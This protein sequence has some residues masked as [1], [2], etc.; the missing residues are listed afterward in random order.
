MYQVSFQVYSFA[1]G[2]I[3]QYHRWHGL[4]NTNFLSGLR[5]QTSHMSAGF[6]L[7]ILP[8]WFSDDHLLTGPHMSLSPCVYNRRISVSV[9]M[10]PSY[11]NTSNTGLGPTRQVILTSLFKGPMSTYSHI[12]GVWASIY[13]FWGD[14]S[15]HNTRS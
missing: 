13:K 10:F 12:P 8:P 15:A 11:R 3:T 6:L 1:R 9:Q 14:T 7:L 5:A 4:N 2:A